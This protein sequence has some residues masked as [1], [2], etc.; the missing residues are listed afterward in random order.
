MSAER[1]NNLSDSPFVVWYSV[2]A[3]RRR[4]VLLPMDKQ[5]AGRIADTSL[6]EWGR[7]VDY[8]GLAW[9]NDNESTTRRQVVENGVDYTVETTLWREQGSDVYTLGV[10]VTETGRRS[11]FGKAVSRYGRK[12]PDGRF[13]EGA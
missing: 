6:A 1:R 8:S 12:F 9:A 13:V 7:S 4:L 5:A 11:L 10:R 3:R 2:P